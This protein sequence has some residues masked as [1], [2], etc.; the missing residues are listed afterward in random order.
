MPENFLFE[1]DGPLTTITF[2]R[3]ERRNYLNREVI[4]ELEQLIAQV[5]DDRE[6]R[7]LIL[8]GTGAAFSAGA[9]IPVGTSVG[10]EAQRQD[11]STRNK[12]LPRI[13]GRMFDQITRLDCMTIAAVNG[14]AIGGGWALVLAF[15]FVLAAPEAEF[16][17]PEVDLSSPFT[18]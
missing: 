2:N 5:R 18:G 14:H 13:I 1:K 15:D 3:P 6:T 17:L 8:T 4:A 7:I 9:E 12:G 10:D 16:W 11:Y